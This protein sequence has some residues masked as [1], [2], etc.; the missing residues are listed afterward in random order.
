MSITI[1]CGANDEGAVDVSKDWQGSWSE[2]VKPEDRKLFVRTFAVGCVLNTRERNGY[3]DSD[4]YA[5]YWDEY[6]QSVKTIEYATTRGW[7]YCNHADVD[8]TPE[9]IEKAI[10]YEIKINT[11]LFLA[12]SVEDAKTVA[13]GKTCKVIK[14]RKITKGEIVQVVS[15][16]RNERYGFNTITTTVLVRLTNGNMVYTN[17]NNLEVQN[18]EQYVITEAQALEVATKAVRN[19]NWAS[20]PYVGCSKRLAAALRRI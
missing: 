4:F 5:T 11:P 13:K 18:F 2:S 1:N 17:V 20:M 16:P 10:Q 14:G 15:E 12:N 9:V 8:A 3:D 6:D 7:T 19:S